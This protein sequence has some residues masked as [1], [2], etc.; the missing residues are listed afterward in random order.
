MVAV[1]RTTRVDL[2]RSSFTE[3]RMQT[4]STFV[5]FA[6]DR[7]FGNTTRKLVNIGDTARMEVN[8]ALMI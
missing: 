2:G 6:G 4:Y 7:H 3:F 5:K 8:K 1:R